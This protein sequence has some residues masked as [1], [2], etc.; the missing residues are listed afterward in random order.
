MGYPLQNT[1]IWEMSAVFGF[2]VKKWCVVA[3]VVVVLVYFYIGKNAYELAKVCEGGP[4]GMGPQYG[5]VID[6]DLAREWQH[7]VHDLIEAGKEIAH[8][9]DDDPH[10]FGQLKGSRL[11]GTASGKLPPWLPIAP[12]LDSVRYHEVSAR[13]AGCERTA[14]QVHGPS[15]G[16]MD[17]A[18]DRDHVQR[19][20]EPQ[21][22][23]NSYAMRHS[24]GPA[25]HDYVR[26]SPYGPPQHY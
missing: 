9:H 5:L 18:A 17:D 11:E 1:P 2:D 10:H 23:I 21:Q 3:W 6:T 12:D 24:H 26:H 15:Y 4:V 19:S 7:I 20:Y 22:Q 13:Q 14:L 25:Q 8:G 16:A